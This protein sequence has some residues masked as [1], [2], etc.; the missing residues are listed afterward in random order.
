MRKCRKKRKR[1]STGKK[2]KTNKTK[3][4]VSTTGELGLSPPRIARG[5]A[6]IPIR[7][8]PGLGCGDALRTEHFLPSDELTGL[9]SIPI[10][11]TLADTRFAFFFFLL[12]ALC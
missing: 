1:K 11:S 10:Y 12:L 6:V 3:K 5:R 2:S 9:D 7:N 4:K 8:V